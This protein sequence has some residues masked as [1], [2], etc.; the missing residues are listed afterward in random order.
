MSIYT[1][2]SETLTDIADAIRGKTGSSALIP[3]ENMASEIAN[4]PSGGGTEFD[5]L[6]DWALYSHVAA[7]DSISMPANYTD[8]DHLA[9]AV[10]QDNVDQDYMK[11]MLNAYLQSYVDTGYSNG[12]LFII[13]TA[14]I[15]QAPSRPNYQLP[16]LLGSAVGK[17]TDGWS[18]INSAEI[19]GY[20][21][22]WQWQNLYLICFGFND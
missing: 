9:I 3:T 8:Y 11:H 22:G 2:Q 6:I 10:I 13:D 17:S 14:N 21:Y 4:I 7:F 15:A 20:N 19:L 12:T 18:Y 1:I 16:L 5:V